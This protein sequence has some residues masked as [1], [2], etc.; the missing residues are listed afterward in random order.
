MS[1]KIDIIQVDEKIRKT[2]LKKTEKIPELKLKLKE[3][4]NSLETVKKDSI[5]REL[6][7]AKKTLE[8]DIENYTKREDY[9][10]YVLKTLSLIEEYK[11]ILNTPKKLNFM[12]KKTKKNK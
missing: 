4:E 5:K 3:I 6:L 8:K 10:F 1:N 9:N 12:G 7:F 2:L 11:K